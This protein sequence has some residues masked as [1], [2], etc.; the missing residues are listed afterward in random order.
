MSH[1]ILLATAAALLMAGC[2]T[3][4]TRGDASN[5]SSAPAA[6]EAPLADSTRINRKISLA[7]GREVGEFSILKQEDTG[8]APVGFNETLYTVRT[9]DA[10]TYKC[11]IIEPSGFGR[12]MTFGMGSGSGAMCTDFTKGSKQQGMTNAASCNQLLRAA[13]KC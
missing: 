5:G 3:A 2:G 11:S 8:S 12:V 9:R 10:R 6:A 4:I 1:A 13:G 7:I